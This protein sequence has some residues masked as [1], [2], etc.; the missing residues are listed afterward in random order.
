MSLKEMRFKGQRVFVEVDE[1][2]AP[3]VENGRARMRYKRDADRV[4]EPSVRN[5]T[6]V[7]GTPLEG[8]A[9]APP[10]KSSPARR[11]ARPEP[12]KLD[13]EGAIVAY[14]DGACLGNPGPAGLGYA[15]SFPDGERIARGEPLGES[16]NN[17]AELAAI[18]R[19][20]ELMEGRDGPAVIY[21]D[22][23]Y[24]IGLLTKGWKAKANKEIV[25]GVRRALAGRRNVTLR[26]VKGHA[27]VPENELVDE[28]ARAAAESQDTVEE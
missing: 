18:G 7:D 1:S 20:L 2:G 24:A 5:L 25:A 12:E 22:S 28:L 8:A 19:A 17:V 16:T 4:Y 15:I 10:R 9:A 21:S 26:K 6:E 13:E 23:E 27:G 11:A 14:T 3:L